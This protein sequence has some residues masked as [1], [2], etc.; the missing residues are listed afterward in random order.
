MWKLHTGVHVALIF[1][2]LWDLTPKSMLVY[3]F[4]PSDYDNAAVL[5]QIIAPR[6]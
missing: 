2:H 6:I 1:S 4:N 5:Y 3:K